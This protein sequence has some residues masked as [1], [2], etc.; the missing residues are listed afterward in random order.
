MKRVLPPLLFLLAIASL[1][2][3]P[4]GSAV[5]SKWLTEFE[6]DPAKLSSVGRNPFFVL[7]PGFYRV[8]RGG[9]VE[10]VVTVLHQTKLVNGVE[11]RVV[12]ERE[13]AGGR[14]TEISLNYYAIHKAT[15]D[16]LYF[17]EWVDN[18][19]NGK[20]VD[21]EGTWIAGEKGAK[22]GLIMPGEPR[23]GFRHYQEQAPGVA[24]D[25][26]EILSTSLTVTTPAGTFENCVKTGESSPMIKGMAEV[27]YFAPGIGLVKFENLEL[28]EHGFRDR[29]TKKVQGDS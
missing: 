9:N 25:R 21:H 2:A 10:V 3:A 20:V 24:L 15:R 27:K 22:A 7:E 13:S 14:L 23:V 28:V 26:A 1:G 12:E 18:Y 29:P 19:R 16:V 11:T 8:L 5:R 6:T 4:G 17:G